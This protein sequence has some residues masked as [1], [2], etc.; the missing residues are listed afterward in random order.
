VS[1]RGDVSD[2]LP[3]DTAKLGVGA[4]LG[5]PL[6]PPRRGR[7]YKVP[8]PTVSFAG[9][10]PLV[11]AAEPT[12]QVIAWVVAVRSGRIRLSTM[13]GL[14]LRWP[15]GIRLAIVES[16]L[17]PG[18]RPCPALL[19]RP[20]ASKQGGG[21]ALSAE[22]RLSLSR[23]HRRFLGIDASDSQVLVAFRQATPACLLIV[24]T[25]SLSTLLSEAWPNEV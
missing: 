12:E 6:P 8:P 19:V 18:H 13:L 24:G 15:S 7:V 5:L 22:G 3:D 21:V 4:A 14:G 16:T 2:D 25:P 23:H 10:V 11:S 9:A 1:S 20:T 17:A